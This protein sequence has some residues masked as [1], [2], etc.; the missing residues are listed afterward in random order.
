[1][2]FLKLYR[3][4]AQHRWFLTGLLAIVWIVLVNRFPEGYIIVGGDV[5][6]AI[7]L[8]EQ[9]ANLH[10]GWFSGRGS[11]FYGLFYLLESFGISATAQL[12]WYIGV[13][14]LGAYLSFWTF[15]RLI[16]PRA[17]RMV[18][19]GFSL[20]Y[21]VNVYTLYIFTAPWG[22]TSYQILYVFIPALSGL[23]ITALVT[24][25]R[26]FT[27]LFLLVAAFASMSFINPA[28]AVSLTVYFLF[29]TLLMFIGR[30]VPFER[31]VLKRIAV[32]IVG[33]LFLNAYWILPLVPQARSGIAELRDSTDIVLTESLVKTS[34]AIYDTLRLLQTYEQKIYYPYNFPY[35]DVAWMKYMIVALTFLP[36]WLVL[37]GTIRQRSKAER[38]VFILFFSLMV[39]FVA[40]VARVRFPFDAINSFLFQL[41]G[42][43]AL[44]GWDKLAIYTP[45]LLSVLLL[46][47]FVISSGKKYTRFLGRG[48]ALVAFLLALPWY[49]GDIQTKLS[50]IL[51]NNKKKDFQ[52]AKYSALVKIPEPYFSVADVFRTD[53]AESKISMLPFSPGSSVGRI[54]L[55]KWKVNGPHPAQMLYAKPYVE[56]N[57]YYLGSWIFAK[58]FDRREYDPRWITDLYGLLG[59]GYVFYHQDAKSDARERFE[60]ARQYLEAQG[61]L[62]P[63]T[64]NSSFILY[65]LAPDALF[66]YV[67]SGAESV[68]M[69]PTVK[70]L[71]E[72]IRNFKQQVSAVSY[73]RSY[74]KEI[75][76]ESGALDPSSVLY[77]NE[78]YDPLWR[79]EYLSSEGTRS[80]L[81]REDAVRYANAWD[82]AGVDPR[83]RVVLYYLP[84]R[85][86]SAGTLLSGATLVIVILSLASA[87]RKT[88]KQV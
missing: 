57:G 21:A 15:A 60:P 20:F 52:D 69:E 77:L 65:R 78:R 88:Q 51:A 17:S 41:P 9:Y 86:L 56:L 63:V 10:F 84:A 46:E 11:L 70:N 54:N 45:F 53:P 30:L 79:G 27:L 32:L 29:L 61:F 48:F 35:P 5:L 19:A 85:L 72:R 24:R 4:C 22:F 66:P 47:F 42:L 13:F 59:I 81:A 38:K 8:R 80:S 55:P 14:L 82:L 64:E 28:F 31:Q 40:L 33:A 1:M 25:Q 18:T 2:T 3:Y 50:Y 74:P 75:V 34:N 87:H 26:R 83:G 6:Q 76:I 16:F 39:V 49:A 71:S 12:S 43:N 36:F 23:Y 68:A 37:G 7:N 44:R 62:R 58:E 73:T 67:Y